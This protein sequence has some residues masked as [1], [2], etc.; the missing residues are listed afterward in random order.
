[1]GRSALGTVVP[2]LTDRGKS[3][4]LRLFV[5]I[6]LADDVRRALDETMRALRRAGVP[7][8][9]VRW[10]RPE[11]VHLTLKFLGATPAARVP[12]ISDALTGA[13][14]GARRF[15]LRPTG[16]GSFGGRPN[17]RVVWVG[18]GGDSAALSA[19]AARVESALA[20]L[21]FPT[22]QRP[23]A[24][25]LTLARVRDGTPPAEREQIARALDGAHAPPYPVIHV[26]RVSLM[27]STLGRGGAVYD[28]VTV[29]PLE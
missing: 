11:G 25:H 9:A 16:V 22:E 4:T 14:R 6:E 3:E 12:T 13:V 20:P 5:A 10:V 2:P 24:A 1:M 17:L 23:F 19:L 7:D 18:V 15:E 28:A 26:E 27:R 21:G 29:F 8:D